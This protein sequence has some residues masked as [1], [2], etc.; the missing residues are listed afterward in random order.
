MDVETLKWLAPMAVG[1]VA[2]LIALAGLFRGRNVGVWVLAAVLSAAL[3]GA[4]V[5]GRISLSKEGLIIETVVAGVESLNELRM[6][7][8][9]NAMAIASLTSQIGELARVSAETP[10]TNPATSQAFRQILTDSNAIISDVEVNRQRLDAILQTNE[11]ITRT[12]QD[13]QP[14]R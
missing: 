9:D 7:V 8:D 13:L 14:V 3:V 11:A 6:A 4:G 2:L 12:L 5:F 1:A 10:G